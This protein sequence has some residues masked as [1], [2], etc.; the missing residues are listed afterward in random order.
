MRDASVKDFCRHWGGDEDSVVQELD[1]NDEEAPAPALPTGPR[2]PIVLVWFDAMETPEDEVHGALVERLKDAYETDGQA[3]LAA[4]VDLKEFAK[5]FAGIPSRLEERAQG[6]MHL[7]EVHQ[8]KMFS[9]KDD[10][11]S[12]LETVK[13]LRAW[14]APRISATEAAPADTKEVTNE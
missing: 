6:W 9:L 13:L 5:R 11:Q 2:K 10:A 12:Q 4:L 7:G 3:I 1:F 14:A 8:I